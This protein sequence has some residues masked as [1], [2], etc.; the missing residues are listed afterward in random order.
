M[1]WDVVNKQTQFHIRTF[2]WAV[3]S[4]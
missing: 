2:T 3:N 1:D 4:I